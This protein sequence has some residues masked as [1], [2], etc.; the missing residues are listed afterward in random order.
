MTEIFN[1]HQ[2]TKRRQEL[3]RNMTQSENILWSKIRRKQ[4]EGL[5]FRRQYSVDA[6]VIDFYCPE[7]RLAIEIDGESHTRPEMQEYDA[8]REEIIKQ[9]GISFV[10]ITNDEVNNYLD[11]ALDKVREASRKKKINAA[12]PFPLI[13]GKTQKGSTIQEKK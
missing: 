10:R 4:I 11:E 8:E 12:N 6:F 5:R 3:R 2:L 9:Y 7:V 1:K 13:K